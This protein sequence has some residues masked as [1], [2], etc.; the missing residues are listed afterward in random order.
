ML[1]KDK[2]YKEDLID[3]GTKC[4]KG[5][6]SEINKMMQQSALTDYCLRNKDK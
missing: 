4:E 3:I 6:T 2:C 1:K 5:L